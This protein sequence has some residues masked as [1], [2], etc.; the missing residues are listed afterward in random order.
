MDAVSAVIPAPRQD[1]HV[2]SVKSD[3]EVEGNNILNVTFSV[4]RPGAGAREQYFEPE[5][6]QHKIYLSLETL[7]RL[8]TIEVLPFDDNICIREPCLNYETCRTRLMFGAA[9]PFIEGASILFRS[10]HP[11]KTYSCECPT[12]FTGEIN[13]YTCNIEVN[14]CYSNPCQ[15]AGTCVSKEGGYTCLCQGWKLMSL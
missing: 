9:K 6:V 4:A 13:H 8:S 3:S 10:I 7:V 11:I 2:F 14:M 15:N 1:V 5:Y 12:G